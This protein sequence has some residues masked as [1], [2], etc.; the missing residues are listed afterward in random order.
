MASTV[1]G[2]VPWYP[3]ILAVCLS[4][5]LCGCGCDLGGSFDDTGKVMIITYNVQN[6]FDTF[7]TGNEYPEYTPE[8]GWS[9]AA[10]AHRLERTARVITQGHEQIPDILVLQ[11]LEHIGVLED[12]LKGPLKTRGYQW[13][14]TTADA[15]SAIQTA[16]ASRYPIQDA[17]IHQADHVRSVLEVDIAIGSESFTLFALH[18]KSR[19]EGVAETEPLRI[20][21]AEIIS[22]RVQRLLE[23]QPLKPVVIAGDFNESAD[24]YFREKQQFQTALVPVQASRA[25][26]Y[27]DLGSLIVG[28]SPP[29]LQGWYSWWLDTSET[30]LSGA[31]G[32]YWYEGVWETFDQI[33]LSPAFFDGFGLE[34]AHGHVG[35][36]QMLFD[37]HGHPYRWDVRKETGVS[38]HLPVAVTLTSR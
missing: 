5:C 24:T 15:D 7:V 19:R 25:Q 37:E 29:A 27:G 34:Y 17:R 28:G 1:R 26:E 3:F 35:S 10:Y 8:E 4:I 12:L 23:K 31:P 11:E 22:E 9:A 18:A 20:A 6:L 30:L 32:S 2:P 36:S 16:V 38:D 14:A 13:Y 33:L 21:V